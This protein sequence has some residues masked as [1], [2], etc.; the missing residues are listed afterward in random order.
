MLKP[1]EITSLSH[2]LLDD[3]LDNVP[4]V[5]GNTQHL[6][7]QFILKGGLLMDERRFII[8]LRHYLL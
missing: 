2:L 1:V 6:M 4:G 5:H 8:N 7:Y 3:L